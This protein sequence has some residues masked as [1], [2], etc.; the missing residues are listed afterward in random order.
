MTADNAALVLQLGRRAA[1]ADVENSRVLARASRAELP[2]FTP[3]MPDKCPIIARRGAMLDR[4][5]PTPC[6]PR[7]WF[8]RLPT[9]FA[10]HQPPLRQVGISVMIFA[11][12]VPIPARSATRIRRYPILRPITVDDPKPPA[13]RAGRKNVARKW[14]S[15]SRRIPD[16]NATETRPRFYQNVLPE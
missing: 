12:R 5:P 13:N 2:K 10:A 1:S 9:H 4:R 7:A 16:M 14:N 8:S 6:R 3:F 11:L 15:A